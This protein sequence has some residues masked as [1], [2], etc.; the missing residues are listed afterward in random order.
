MD[1]KK[2]LIVDSSSEKNQFL[3][4]LVEELKK[5]NFYFSILLAGKG[6]GLERKEWQFSRRFMGP[7]IKN[8]FFAA[9][10]IILLPA[11][12]LLYFFYAA[13]LKFSKKITSIILVGWK[14]KIFLSPAGRILRINTIW[15]ENPGVDYNNLGRMEKFLYKKSSKK[16]RI[17]VFSSLVKH[18]LSELGL[19][20]DNIKIFQPGIRLNLYEHQDNIFSKL[21]QTEGS[22]FKKKFFTIGTVVDLDKRQHVEK[23]LQVVKICSEV[24][25]NI[26]LIVIG[27]GQERKNLAW[28]AKKMGIDSCVWFVGEHGHVRKWLYSF[29]VYIVASVVL[30]MNDLDVVLKCMSAGLPVIGPQGEGLEDI[31]YNDKT[32][33][34]LEDFDS[35][36]IARQVI[37]LYQDGRFRANLGMLAKERVKKFFNL[38]EQVNE[39]EK[40]I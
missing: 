7:E 5:K 2:I 25:P 23:L 8:K 39:F 37:R 12:A 26:Q 9:E 13:Y 21:A 19:A 18:S 31:V 28:S 14:E 15:I 30:K 35:E 16:A 17:V 10:F 4:D 20:G 27:E 24:I 32:G 38:A 40:I 33:C 6:S 3:A 29:D 1:N 22:K 34:L 36:M 11:L